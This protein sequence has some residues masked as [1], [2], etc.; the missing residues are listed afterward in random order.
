MIRVTNKS[1]QIF[2]LNLLAGED[3]GE[4]FEPTT[5]THRQVTSTEDGTAG[6]RDV[7]LSQP[8]SITWLAGETR[9]VP[10]AVASIEEFRSA[11]RAGRL[12]VVESA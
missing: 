3:Y 8:A 9:E 10:D 2:T 12:L 7:E 11:W 1:R 6:F 4:D 5:T